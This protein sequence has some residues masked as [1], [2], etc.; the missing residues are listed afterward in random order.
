MTVCITGLSSATR[1]DK[2]WDFGSGGT[3]SPLE[4]IGGNGGFVMRGPADAPAAGGRAC[5]LPFLRAVD[6]FSRVRSGDDLPLELRERQQDLQRQPSQGHPRLRGMI[7]TRYLPQAW[8][9]FAKKKMDG[10][11]L[12]GTR[13]TNVS[14][15][16]RFVVSE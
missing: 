7:L 8:I 16:S 1:T 6:T 12:Q 9:S 2:G 3:G 4:H 10:C 13:T 5:R 15:P 14:T 11:G